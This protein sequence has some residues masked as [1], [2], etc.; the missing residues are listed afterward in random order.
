MHPIVQQFS[1]MDIFKK[2]KISEIEELIEKRDIVFKE[3]NKNVLV[4]ARGEEIDEIMVLIHGKI[5]AEMTD[6]N[7]KN[8]V[9]EEINAPSLLAISSTLA[10]NSEL[11]VDII[12]EEKS[13][14]GY[15]PKEKVFDLCI[16]NKEFLKELI[17]FLGTKFNF[18][19]QKLWFITLNNLRDKILLYISSKLKSEDDYIIL[20]NSIEQL[21]HLFGSTRPALS[22]A[23]SKLESEGVIKKEGNK[24]YILDKSK[25]YG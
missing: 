20:E 21:S 5:R 15:L 11:P 16:Q 24:V 4:K 8:L 22:R 25:L 19:S 12:T 10:K 7:G 3:Y 17:E 14:I 1:K 2:L 6:Y 13:V 9:I 23:F 18:I